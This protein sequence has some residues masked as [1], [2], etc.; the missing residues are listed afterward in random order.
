[1]FQS[2]A[3]SAARRDHDAPIGYLGGAPPT[4]TTVL[5]RDMER[6]GTMI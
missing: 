6:L 2:V 3:S 1:M 4:S 5:N